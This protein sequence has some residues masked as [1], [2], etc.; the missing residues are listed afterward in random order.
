M[1]G[2]W[3]TNVDAYANKFQNCKGIRFCTI[4]N[5]LAADVLARVNDEFPLWSNDAVWHCRYSNPLEE[6]L[7]CSDMERLDRH[8]PTL[9]K[10]LRYLNSAEFLPYLRLIAGD[11]DLHEDPTFHGAGAHCIP[12]GGH[13]DM[14]VDYSVHP[15][16]HKQRK[17]NLLLYLT[18]N[19][20][21]EWHT[22]DLWLTE[23]CTEEVTGPVENTINV[24]NNMCAVFE[25]TDCSWH[26]HPRALVTDGTTARQALASYYIGEI[27]VNKEKM[28]ENRP[29]ACFVSCEQVTDCDGKKELYKIRKNRC[30]TSNDLAT[31]CP[32]WKSSCIAFQ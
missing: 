1:L 30:I 15:I 21:V 27:P 28:R 19:W 12:P 32:N 22:G 3:V 6:K 2:D 4:D 24:R 8:A 26:G 13:L 17:L 31:H 16:L 11:D 9:A 7:A 25:P 5:F 14:H 18:P 10:V 23:T 29:K 20:S